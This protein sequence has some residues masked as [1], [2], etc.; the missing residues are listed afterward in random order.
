MSLRELLWI[1]N[2]LKQGYQPSGSL[3]GSLECLEDQ[4]RLLGQVRGN[5]EMVGLIGVDE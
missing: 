5:L 3:R 4:V 1:D 2:I